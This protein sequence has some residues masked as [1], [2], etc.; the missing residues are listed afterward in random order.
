MKES[1]VAFACVLVIPAS[2]A[3]FAINSALFIKENL[4][5]LCETNLE[6]FLVN[7]NFFLHYFPLKSSPALHFGP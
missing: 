2:S 4:I 6:A 3:S 5:G 7:K 1:S